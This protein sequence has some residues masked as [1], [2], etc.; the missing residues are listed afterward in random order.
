MRFL[1]TVG[2]GNGIYSWVFYGDH[3]MPEDI[4]I[5]FEKTQEEIKREEAKEQ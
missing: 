3:E 2:P 4:T 5:L 1:Y